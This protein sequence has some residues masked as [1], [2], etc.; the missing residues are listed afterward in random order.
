[1]VRSEPAPAA[2]LDAED[3]Q[4]LNRICLLECISR[5]R[6]IGTEQSR[7]SVSNDMLGLCADACHHLNPSNWAKPDAGESVTA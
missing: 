6:N 1:M 2:D 5:H 3:G 7:V 4:P